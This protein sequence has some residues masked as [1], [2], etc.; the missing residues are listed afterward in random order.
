MEGFLM[1]PRRLLIGLLSVAFLV[2]GSC[3]VSSPDKRLLLTFKGNSGRVTCVVYSPN[4]TD[5]ASCHLEVLARQYQHAYNPL[6][7]VKIW[8]ARTGEER[9]AIN[10]GKVT[11]SVAFFPNGKNLAG[12]VGHTARIWDGTS[13]KQKLALEGHAGVVRDLDIS[14]NGKWLATASMDG[15]VKVWDAQTGA[16]LRTFKGNPKGVL[17][18]S[19]SPDGKWVAATSGDR[20]IEGAIRIWDWATETQV[21]NLPHDFPLGKP[22]F[23][24]D[25]KHLAC[26]EYGGEDKYST[27]GKV[28][29]WNATTGKLL[30]RLQAHSEAVTCIAYSRNG[31]L[32]ASGSI[33]GTVIVRDAH[34]G[35]EVLT[36]DPH[37]NR[38]KHSDQI[39]NIAFSPREDRL[40]VAA[41]N[42]SINIWDITDVST[43][44]IP[45]TDR[46]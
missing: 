15:T 31:D 22:L 32:L 44:E 5:I 21:L 9:L 25:D 23:S 6:G 10:K 29:V 30:Y 7:E 14:R 40:A 26:Y 34:T 8:D 17:Y 41:K 43:Q 2:L 45:K 20:E 36:L 42:G 46:E 1:S 39:T 19:F 28:E 11:R 24:P 38:R 16:C 13:G 18:V 4:G 27:P 12:A 33:D 3:R 37:W 35:E